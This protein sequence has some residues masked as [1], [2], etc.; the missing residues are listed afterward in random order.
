[1]TKKEAKT[2]L[3]DWEEEK[4]KRHFLAR[5]KSTSLAYDDT[6]KMKLVY[7]AQITLGKHQFQ[8]PLE[9]LRT[10]YPSMSETYYNRK[11]KQH[12]IQ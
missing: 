6:E 3:Q 2:I 12:G 4:G 10:R 11:R 9:Q 5:F 7:Q 1:M 8:R